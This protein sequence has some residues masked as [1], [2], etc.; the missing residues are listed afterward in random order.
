MKI[1]FTKDTRYESEGRNKGPLYKAGDLHDFDEAFAERWL[2]RGVAEVVKPRTSHADAKPE[3]EQ[4]APKPTEPVKPVVT[5]GN[6]DEKPA[7]VKPAPA[8]API[9]RR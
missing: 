7:D 6:V 3:A 4:S 1:R 8:A 9:P 2:R 5:E